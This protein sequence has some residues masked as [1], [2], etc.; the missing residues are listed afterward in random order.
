MRNIEEIIISMKVKENAGIGRI[1]RTIRK[2]KD[3]ENTGDYCLY[4]RVIITLSKNGFLIP[5]HQIIRHFRVINNE[6]YLE[7]EKRQLLN[8]LKEINETMYANKLPKESLKTTKK[9]SRFDV[10]SQL[11]HMYPVFE[12]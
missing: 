6:D 5:H 9:T 3:E 4:S 2:L 1:F 7:E 8:S 11:V 10:L 12:K